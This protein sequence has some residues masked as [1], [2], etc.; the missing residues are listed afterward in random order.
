M[1]L[2]KIL[3]GISLQYRFLMDTTCHWSPS[4]Y[5]AKNHHCLGTILQPV[6]HLL[7]NPPIKS[8]SFQFAE[9]DVVRDHVKG[10]TEVQ[11]D[12][13]SGFSHV[14][15]HS[16]ITI[17]SNMRNQEP[18]GGWPAYSFPVNPSCAS[19]YFLPYSPWVL[20]PVTMTNQG[21]LRVFSQLTPSAFTNASHVGPQ[22]FARPAFFSIP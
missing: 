21:L 20:L 7:H 3:K 5:W 11:T 15:W 19:W 9:K 16:Y 22:T 1:P 18:K 2:K 6:P 17:K 14:P 4:G 10:L 13:I 8:L 12:Y